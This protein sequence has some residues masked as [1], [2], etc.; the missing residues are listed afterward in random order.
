MLVLT[1]EGSKGDQA[2]IPTV[3]K[4]NFTQDNLQVF[5]SKIVSYFKGT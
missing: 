5:Q 3:V 2:N 4:G 1:T